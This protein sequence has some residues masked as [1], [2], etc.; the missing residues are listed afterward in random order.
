MNKQQFTINKLIL[1]KS[2]IQHIVE[3]MNSALEINSKLPS[4]FDEKHVML[5]YLEKQ[6]D[7]YIQII[8][9]INRILSDFK[10]I[11]D[12]DS[13]YSNHLVLQTYN[14]MDCFGDPSYIH[15]YCLSL[16][17]EDDHE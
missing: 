12:K 2:N 14:I 13:P 3:W 17:E 15:D 1:L 5:P 16:L 9:N 10:K 4:D 7:L 8:E 6:K 11:E